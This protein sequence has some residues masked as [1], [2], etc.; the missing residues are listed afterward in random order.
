MERRKDEGNNGRKGEG[1]K[2]RK[3][4]LTTVHCQLNRG[5][6][7][8]QPER[9]GARRSQSRT[10]NAII[11]ET[12]CVTSLGIR[13]QAKTQSIASLQRMD[14]KN[15]CQLNRN[16]HA[17]LAITK[18]RFRSIDVD[19]SRLILS[20]KERLITTNELKSQFFPSCR[21]GMCYHINHSNQINHNSDR[22]EANYRKYFPFCPSSLSSLRP[23]VLSSLRPFAPSPFRPLFSFHPITNLKSIYH[24][25]HQNK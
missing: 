24:V 8:K 10:D 21:D 15:N 14:R 11:V 22:V 6:T 20:T 18:E 13:R 23:F 7:T 1:M 5:G 9:S 17:L 16:F 4:E 19:L 2:G 3:E 12:Q 25:L